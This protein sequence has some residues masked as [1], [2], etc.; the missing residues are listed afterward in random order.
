LRQFREHEFPDRTERA[1]VD[2]LSEI[3]N[4]LYEYDPGIGVSL[5]R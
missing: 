3:L 2:L 4:T 5:V 1:R